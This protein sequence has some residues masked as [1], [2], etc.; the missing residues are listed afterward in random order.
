M[1]TSL[2]IYSIIIVEGGKNNMKKSELIKQTIKDNLNYLQILGFKKSADSIYNKEFNGQNLS[3]SITIYLC[4][5]DPEI[6]FAE[7]AVRSNTEYKLN[8]NNL[9]EEVDILREKANLIN[10][11]NATLRALAD[12]LGSF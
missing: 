3:C 8:I 1:F 9:D 4:Y 2:F 7:P 5:K 11:A 6:R 12:R 10:E